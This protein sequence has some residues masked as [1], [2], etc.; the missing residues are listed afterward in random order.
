MR[1]DP[2]VVEV[3]GPAVVVEILSPGTRR[4][5][6]VDK[7]VGDFEVPGVMQY[8]SVDAGRALVLHHRRGEGVI[9]TRICPEG[10]LR[11]DPPGLTLAV[12]DLL[13]EP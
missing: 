10:V 4:T 6:L 7:L 11:L 2:D 1:L 9:E 3:P 13:A 8:L 5:D 12:A